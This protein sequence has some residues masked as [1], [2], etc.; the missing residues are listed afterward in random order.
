M[1]QRSNTIEMSMYSR[2]NIRH[3]SHDYSKAGWYF[4]TIRIQ[5]GV[6]LFGKATPNGIEL[7]ALGKQAQ[8]CWIEIPQHFPRVLLGDYVIM[9]NHIHGLIY[10][11]NDGHICI[12]H[13]I[14][15]S[16]IKYHGKDIIHDDQLQPDDTNAGNGA[17]R[18]PCESEVP[19]IPPVPP[20]AYMTYKSNRFGAPCKNSLG[21]II[22]NYK[23]AVTRWANK[24]GYKSLFDWQPRY[25]DRVIRDDKELKVKQLYIQQNSLKWW[26]KYGEEEPDDS[27]W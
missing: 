17:G 4:L 9:P 1:A 22:G 19:S 21:V 25:N 3:S 5:R 23:S 6:C 14:N 8:Q 16:D 26:E 27:Y 7:S 11:N 18:T 24:N 10:L 12:D 13:P 20:P 15:N 2:K